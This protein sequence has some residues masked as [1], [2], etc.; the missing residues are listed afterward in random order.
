MPFEDELTEVLHSTATAFEPDL[1]SL[2]NSGL[3]E[4]RRRSRR[5]NLGVLG[6]VTALALVGIGGAAASGLLGTAQGPA[7]AGPAAGPTTRVA[8][9]DTASTTRLPKFTAQQMLHS[10]EALLPKGTITDAHSTGFTS[11]TRDGQTFLS[12]PTASLVLTDAKGSSSI[13]IT[14]S[15]PAASV[16]DPGLQDYVTCPSHAARPDITCT[17]TKLPDGSVLAITQGLENPHGPSK[18]K[19]WTAWL[20]TRDGG[21]IELDET[22]AASEKGTPSRPVPILTAAQLRSVVTAPLWGQLA[23]KLPAPAPVYR[24]DDPS[25]LAVKTAR[26]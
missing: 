6:G 17:R 14:V 8:T 20:A 25:A 16:A 15:R 26:Q 7:L 4:G 11:E 3:G 13:A 12:G 22:N 21:L 1:T 23:S 10:F 18:E 5:R 19:D 9:A 2:V 24:T